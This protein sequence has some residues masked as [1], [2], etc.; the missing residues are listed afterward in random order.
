MRLVPVSGGTMRVSPDRPLQ[1]GQYTVPAGV[2]I[3]LAVHREPGQLLG[4]MPTA[5]LHWQMCRQPLRK[6]V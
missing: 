6:P 4:W 2:E 5:T 3:I 1:L